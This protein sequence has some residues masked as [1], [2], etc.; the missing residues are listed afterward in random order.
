MYTDLTSSDPNPVN[1]MDSFGFDL[2]RSASEVLGEGLGTA[3]PYLALILVVFLSGWFQH[4]MIRRRQ[5]GAPINPTQEMIMKFMPFFLPV[6]AFTLP[7]AIVIYFLISNLYRIAQQYYITRS[8]YSGDESLGAQLREQRE[9]TKDEK[10]TPQDSKKKSSSKGGSKNGSK[11]ASSA[12]GGS[13]KKSSAAKKK[14]SGQN[15]SHSGSG[16]NGGKSGKHK[17]STPSSARGNSPG[18]NSSGRNASARQTVQPKARKK[19]K[20]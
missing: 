13:P 2:A 18:R 20:R 11:G 7:V 15:R 1:T 9:S 16:K 6:F 4:Q 12:K 19:K 3:L 14:S 5:T 10:K 8:M 17:S